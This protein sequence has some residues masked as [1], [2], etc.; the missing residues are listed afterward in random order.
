MTFR[1]YAAERMK[2]WLARRLGKWTLYVDYRSG[3]YRLSYE[4]RRVTRV[5]RQGVM[6]PGDRAGL[7]RYVKHLDVLHDHGEP[8]TRPLS[9]RDGEGKSGNSRETDGRTR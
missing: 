7:P 9:G 4:W 2:A 6:R 3:S 8:L 5:H 1:E